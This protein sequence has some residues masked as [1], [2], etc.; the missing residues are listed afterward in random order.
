MNVITDTK[1]INLSPSGATI[2]QN[3]NLNSNLQFNIPFFIKKDRN[4]LYN[5]IKLLHA[6]IPYS[7][8]IVNEYNNKLILSTG[9]VTLPFGNYNANTFL[10]DIQE[11]LPNPM[12][13]TFNSLTG[14]FTLTNN[15]S[16]SILPSSTCS[17][18]MGFDKNKTI[19]SISDNIMMPYPANFLG[20][21]NLYIKT[22]SLIVENY[23]TT[24]KDYITLLTIP[25]NVPPFGIIL[26]DNSASSKNVIKNTNS[27]DYLDVIIVDDNNNTVDFNNIEWTLTLEIE[28]I[29]EIPQNRQTIE[30]YLNQI[31]KY[32]VQSNN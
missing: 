22:P 3:G 19:T 14:K 18:L 1:Q 15:H 9:S 30:E 4:I 7:F 32:S 16:F 5:T 29:I 8:Y 10:R 24:T 21:K 13:I 25:C 2:K 6:E 11:L 28:T 26:F 12:T 17:E 27:M 23:N 20:T 31:Y